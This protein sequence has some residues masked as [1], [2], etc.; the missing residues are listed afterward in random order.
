MDHVVSEWTRSDAQEL[1]TYR[2]FMRVSMIGTICV[3]VLLALM[4]IFLL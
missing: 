3:I 2:G 1:D 4:A